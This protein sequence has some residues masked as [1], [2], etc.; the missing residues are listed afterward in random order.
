MLLKPSRPLFV[1]G[2]RCI[3]VNNSLGSN[4]VVFCACEITQLFSAV[5]YVVRTVPKF[6]FRLVINDNTKQIAISGMKAI[7]RQRLMILT[8]SVCFH[9]TVMASID[10]ILPSCE[11]QMRSLE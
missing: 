10:G 8:G 11:G 9:H 1:T 2:T 6:D 7:R 5:S 3:P 4:A